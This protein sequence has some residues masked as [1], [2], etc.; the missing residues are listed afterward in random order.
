MNVVKW[1]KCGYCHYRSDL[2][3]NLSLK[4]LPVELSAISSVIIRVIH[5][6]LKEGN[7]AENG[8]KSL[9]VT[10]NKVKCLEYKIPEHLD[11]SD[12]V[13]LKLKDS[14]ELE[15]RYEKLKTIDRCEKYYAQYADAGCRSS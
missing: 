4:E 14:N 6:E 5:Q 8:K 7:T 12:S 9:G 11:E 10:E 3:L 13:K 1:E 2:N 15:A